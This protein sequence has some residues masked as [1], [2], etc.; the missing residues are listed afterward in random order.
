MFRYLVLKSCYSLIM[1]VVLV[2]QCNQLFFYKTHW[3]WFNSG[4]SYMFIS[5]KTNSQKWHVC[6]ENS[7]KEGSSCLLYVMTYDHCVLYLHHF[8]WFSCTSKT[9]LN[10]ASF[11]WEKCQKKNLQL[12]SL[13][14]VIPLMFNKADL[15]LLQSTDA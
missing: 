7:L 15:H 11:Q 1:T 3:N 6:R 9:K 13:H 5:A 12:C 4:Q 10:K 14:R 2:Q 8:A